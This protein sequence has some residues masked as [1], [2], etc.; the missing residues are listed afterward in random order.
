M[1]WPSTDRDTDIVGHVP[2]NLAPRMSALLMRDMSKA[3]AE[4]TGAKSTGKLTM[5][6]KSHLSTVYMDLTFIL[7][8]EGVG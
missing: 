3:F 4:I 2:Y 5:V 1:Q 6:W 7:T 8:N